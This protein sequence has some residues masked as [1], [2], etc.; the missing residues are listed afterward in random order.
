MP[1]ISECQELVCRDVGLPMKL[2]LGSG[3]SPALVR[4]RHTAMWLAQEVTGESLTR[5]GHAFSRDHT[6]ILH[7]VGQIERLRAEDMEVRANTDRLAALMRTPRAAPAPKTPKP[8][9]ELSERRPAAVQAPQRDA[10]PIAPVAPAAVVRLPA[11]NPLRSLRLPTY[12]PPKTC[13][14]IE[15]DPRAPNPHCGE[16]TVPGKPYCE[17]H[18]ARAY[19]KPK[20]PAEVEPV[21]WNLNPSRSKG[22]AA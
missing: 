17:P 11:V 10:T 1:T 14:W 13:Q 5:I 4:H 20:A 21:K 2:L 7:A 22:S 9:V 18:A 19:Q 6:T 15:G 12:A 8:V 3:R 16:P